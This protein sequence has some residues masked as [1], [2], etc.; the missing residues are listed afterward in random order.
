MFTE[1]PEYFRT[2]ASDSDA[3]G[4]HSHRQQAAA[5]DIDLLDAYSRAVVHVVETV[6]PAVVSVSGEMGGEWGGAGSGFLI[7]PDGYAITNSH[8]VGGRR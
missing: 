6:S 4:Q 3:A 7:T 1:L 5:D 8:V 2:A